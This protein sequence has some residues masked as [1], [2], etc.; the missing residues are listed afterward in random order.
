[1]KDEQSNLSGKYSDVLEGEPDPDLLRLIS[2]LDAM[3]ASYEPPQRLAESIEN[4][5]MEKRTQM[6]VPALVTHDAVLP[7]ATPKRDLKSTGKLNPRERR[8]A[9]SWPTRRLGWAIVIIVLLVGS[10]AGAS[11]IL[12]LANND[13]EPSVR[14]VSPPT[15]A[16]V[17]S[18]QRPYVGP[19]HLEATGLGKRV[20]LHQTV[21]GYTVSIDWVYADG[22]HA[23]IKYEVTPG[24]TEAGLRVGEDVYTKLMD[25]NGTL[26]PIISGGHYVSDKDWVSPS[27]STFD[28]SGL[29][30]STSVLN[31]H[32]A[33]RLKARESPIDRRKSITPGTERPRPQVES[34]D[35]TFTFDFS[36]PVLPVRVARVQQS[37]MA[38]GVEVTLEELR[39]GPSGANAIV[40]FEPQNEQAALKWWPTLYLQVGD[41][42]EGMSIPQVDR[43]YRGGAS[44]RFL[45]GGRWVNSWHVVPYE[46][47]EE[48]TIT[49]TQLTGRDDDFVPQIELDGPWT[50]KV[51]LP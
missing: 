43:R 36:V 20:N 50:F 22:N 40:R 2:G 16:P 3:A 26:I 9:I 6:T 45:P 18:L 8:A 31:L 42:H 49:V 47:Q 25:E 21:N 12:S 5:L 23:I 38:D 39:V 51:T 27:Y 19:E 10:G 32:L 15:P 24:W 46:S 28:T 37:V 7:N 1:M 17:D 11:A 41:W 4:A 34:I 44:G 14:V 33:M 30:S 29:P 13:T 48:W 35:G